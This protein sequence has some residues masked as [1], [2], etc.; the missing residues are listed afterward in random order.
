MPAPLEAVEKKDELKEG[1]LKDE[2]HPQ[3]IRCVSISPTTANGQT[4]YLVKAEA[5]IVGAENN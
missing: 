3:E 2:G 4:G 1:W 5:F